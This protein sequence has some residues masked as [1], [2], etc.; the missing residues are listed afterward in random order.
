MEYTILMSRYVTAGEA[1]GWESATN[2]ETGF[3]IVDTVRGNSYLLYKQMTGLSALGKPRV[4]TESFADADTIKAYLTTRRETTELTLTLLFVGPDR[5]TV[6]DNFCEY[7]RGYRLKYW[8]SVRKRTVEM[9]LSDA[10]EP[11]TDLLY[12][13]TP[14]IQADFK[15]T[16][17]GGDTAVSDS[18]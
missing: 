16:N 3:T 6:Y 14:Y 12:G 4:Y 8:D 2:L 11:S 9:F 15:F 17:Y 5:R 10:V 18:I 7:I 13:T 1:P